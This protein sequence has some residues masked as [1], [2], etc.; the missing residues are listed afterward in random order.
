MRE[1]NFTVYILFM[2][3]SWDSQLLYS[4]KNIKNGSHGTIYTF[5]NYFATVFFNFQFQFSVF[6]CI[7]TDPTYGLKLVKFGIAI[8]QYL[9]TIVT[10]TAFVDPMEI[11][12]LVDHRSANVYKDSSLNYRKNGA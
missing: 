11:V 6:S 5:K 10:I 1:T 2:H 8:H 7:Q 3:C 4:E 12:S 9:E